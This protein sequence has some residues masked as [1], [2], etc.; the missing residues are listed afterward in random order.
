VWTT[1]WRLG[2]LTRIT[3]WRNTKTLSTWNSHGEPTLSSTFLAGLSFVSS[4]WSTPLQNYSLRDQ[5]PASYLPLL[6]WE[7]VS[8]KFKCPKPKLREMFSSIFINTAHLVMHKLINL[9]KI[10]S[11]ASS[12]GGTGAHSVSNGYDDKKSFATFT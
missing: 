12:Y 1:F 9:T 6:F 5:L 7:L 3:K 4:R 2:N 11:S 8:F 10:S